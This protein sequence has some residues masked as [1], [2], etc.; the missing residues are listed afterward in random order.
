MYHLVSLCICVP[1]YILYQDWTWLESALD[2]AQQ[3]ARASNEA[4][5]QRLVELEKNVEMLVR[6]QTGTNNDYDESDDEVRC[7]DAFVDFGV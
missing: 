6:L 2:T 7:H 3:S 4:L 1:S 5:M